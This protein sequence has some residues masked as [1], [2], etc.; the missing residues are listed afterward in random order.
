MASAQHLGPRISAQLPVVTVSRASL[1]AYTQPARLTKHRRM[2]LGKSGGL[3]VNETRPFN[4][5]VALHSSTAVRETIHGRAR[6]GVQVG[7]QVRSSCTCACCSSVASALS[8][9]PTHCHPASE[10]ARVC[11]SN[12]W[13]VYSLTCVG[14]RG[15]VRPCCVVR[16]EDPAR[17]NHQVRA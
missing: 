17:A 4:H 15:M 12:S 6:R 16:G 9:P 13:I 10:D 8:L 3:G 7:R 11:A 2:M 5:Y 14:A 1:I